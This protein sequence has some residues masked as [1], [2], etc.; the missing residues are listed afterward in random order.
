[1]WEKRV[2]RREESIASSDT[3][4]MKKRKDISMDLQI[5]KLLVS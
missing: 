3:E 4:S 5:R 1:M 2:S